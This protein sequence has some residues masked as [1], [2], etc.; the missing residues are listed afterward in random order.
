MDRRVQYCIFI[1]LIYEFE[2]NSLHP[3][4]LH[5]SPFQ[6]VQNLPSIGEY[7]GFLAKAGDFRDTTSSDFDNFYIRY[8][9]TDFTGPIVTHCHFL[10]HEDEGMI[11]YFQVVDCLDDE[12]RPYMDIVNGTLNPYGF[13]PRK[14]IVPDECDIFKDREYSTM[15]F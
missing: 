1:G 11:V 4:H 12:N 13:D 2:V 8:Q 5:T 7:V 9:A 10:P 15:K 3:L 14:G 6:I